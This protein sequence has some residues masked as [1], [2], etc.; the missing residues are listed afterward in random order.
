[1][2]DLFAIIAELGIELHPDRI[3][4][5]ADKIKT[6]DSA[7]Q[8]MIIESDFGQ[9][10]NKSIVSEL[11]AVW[12]HNKDISPLEIASA[13]RGASA[14]AI[15]N[16]KRG[17][18]EIVWTGPSMSQIPIRHTE[19]VLCEVINYATRHLFIVSFVAYEIDS[20]IKAM[21][22]AIGRNIQ[23]D[24][25]LELS[26]DYGGHVNQNSIK[27]MKK[28]FPSANI[29]TWSEKSKTTGHIGAI[30]AKCA[31]ADGEI[32]FITSANLTSA[33]MERNVELGVLVRGGKLPSELKK[34]LGSLITAKVFE[35][36]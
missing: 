11:D 26:I 8:F 24:L 27:M 14:A 10:I 15:A 23:I 21:R 22:N 17:K 34:H 3:N 32:A 35:R 18:T 28:L 20:V 12:K 30:H 31:V 5:L 16:E 9:G 2:K 13:L 25:L 29:Y 19:Q 33:A 36:F 4:V 7:E 6:I 1:L